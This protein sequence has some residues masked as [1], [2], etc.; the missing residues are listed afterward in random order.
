[1]AL[2]QVRVTWTG[3]SQP[4]ISTFY[5]D[6]SAG[7]ASQAAAAVSAFMA[8]L[9]DNL[10]SAYTW[11]L[12]PDVR[13]LNEATGALISITPV[14][15]ASA[16]CGSGG[17]LVDLLQGL[18]VWRT[19][20]VVDGRLL[21]GRTFV[22]GIEEGRNAAGGVPESTFRDSVSGTAAAL[23]ATATFQPVVWHR[24][25]YSGPPDARVLDREGSFAE[26]VTGVMSSKWSYL[27]SRRV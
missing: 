26:V 17:T 23:I 1:M 15:P 3:P 8:A 2:W 10:N 25:V 20:E 5:G 4:L 21:R 24:P 7:T 11:T 9:D 14:T 27:S 6:G 19:T 22:P 13:E 16:V 12:E 18:I